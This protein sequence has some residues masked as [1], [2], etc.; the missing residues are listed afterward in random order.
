MY[1]PRS[2]VKLVLIQLLSKTI[3]YNILYINYRIG[4]TFFWVDQMFDLFWLMHILSWTN[5]LHILLEIFTI[6]I[7]NKNV[8]IK[9]SKMVKDHK[10]DYIIQKNS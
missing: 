2:T 5:G 9:G 4:L 1:Q 7:P 10:K 6:L 3:N 8:Y